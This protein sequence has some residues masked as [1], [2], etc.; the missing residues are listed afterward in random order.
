ME[1]ICLGSGSTGNAYIIRHNKECVLVECGFGIRVLTNKLSKYEI[2]LADIKAVLTS[3]QHGD[4]TKSLKNFEKIKVK[5]ISP[6][7]EETDLEQDLTS[8]LKVKCFRTY[9]DVDSYGF[10]FVNTET[11][12]KVLFVNDTQAFEF[13]DYIL[14]EKFDYIFIECNHTRRKIKELLDTADENKKFKLERQLTTH[15]S[16]AGVK[17][18]LKTLDLTKTKEI[19]LMHLSQEAS[20]PEVMKEQVEYEFKKK[21]YICLKEGDLL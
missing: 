1:F 10:I 2:Q 19:Y 8:W 4:H 16:L 14:N 15:L 6:W 12:E 17:R 7:K 11:N 20:E 5:C 3:H 18:M 9:H 21:T 13:E